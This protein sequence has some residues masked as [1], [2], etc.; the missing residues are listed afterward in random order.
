[1][2]ERVGRLVYVDTGP[3]PDGAANVDFAG[4]KAQAD[5]AKLVAANDGWRLPPPPWA[6]LA[7]GVDGVLAEA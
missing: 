5:Q 7:S 4:P 6:D 1:M 2:P 3:L